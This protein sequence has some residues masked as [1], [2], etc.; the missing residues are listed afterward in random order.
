MLGDAGG[1]QLA[2]V[3]LPEAFTK[4]LVGG[5]A[6]LLVDG[7]AALVEALCGAGVALGQ[8]DLVAAAAGVVQGT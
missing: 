5:A 3:R 8:A 2:A 7:A 6:E 4:F 1:L